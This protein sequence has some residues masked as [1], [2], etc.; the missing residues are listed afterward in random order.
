M[1]FALRL[2]VDFLVWV[3]P[4]WRH[5]SQPNISDWEEIDAD[6]DR[7]PDQEGDY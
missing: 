3:R 6:I 7:E 2:L 4:S 1:I 5:T